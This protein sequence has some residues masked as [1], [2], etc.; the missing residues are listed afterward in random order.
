MINLIML[1]GIIVFIIV[2]VTNGF[3]LLFDLLLVYLKIESV[4]ERIWQEPI[5]GLPI[6]IWQILGFTGLAVHFYLKLIVK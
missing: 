3:G 6:L 2:Q 1:I 4:S 5:L